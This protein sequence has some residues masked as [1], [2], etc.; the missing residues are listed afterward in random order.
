MHVDDSSLVPRHDLRRNQLQVSG[1]HDEVDMMLIENLAE[2]RRTRL[3]GR[4][5]YGRHDATA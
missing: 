4:R 5:V 1:E 2:R 3:F